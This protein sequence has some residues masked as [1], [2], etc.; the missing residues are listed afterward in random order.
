M[1]TIE[2]TPGAIVAAVDGSDPALQAARWAATQ[3]RLEG[4][5]LLLVHVSG[6]A[7]PTPTTLRTAPDGDDIVWLDDSIRTSRMLLEE[8]TDVVCSAVPG[9]SIRSTSVRGDAR[10]VLSEIRD[11]HLLVL[12]SRGRG[13]VRSRLLGS[14]SAHVAK[15]VRTPLVV[16]R[17]QSPGA[18]KDG[19]VVAADATAESRPVLEFAYRQASLRGVPLTVLHCLYP[20]PVVATGMAGGYVQAMPDAAEHQRHLAES[21]AGLGETYPDVRVEQQLMHGTVETCLSSYPRPWDLIVVGRH[22]AD[23]LQWLLGATAVTVLEH[24]ASPIAV[25]PEDG[26]D[27]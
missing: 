21:V 17:P 10:D 23:G 26:T 14:V 2:I 3:A 11:A 16:V 25:I 7:R 24:A 12:G 9:V 20:V 8:T 6:R 1:N 22:P 18:L 15:T 19:V 13:A 27:R 4:R 5:P